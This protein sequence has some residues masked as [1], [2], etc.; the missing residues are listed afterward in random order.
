[1]TLEVT[2]LQIQEHRAELQQRG[3]QITRKTDLGNQYD[4]PKHIGEGGDRLLHLRGGLDL[5]IRDNRFWQRLLIKQHHEDTFPVVAKFYLSGGSRVRTKNAPDIAA[6]YEEVAG[7]SYL[8][9]LPSLVETE[10]WP[11]NI[12]NR[13]VMIYAD[14]NYFRGLYP[15]DDQLPRPLQHLMQKTGRFHRS[16]GEMTPAMIQILQQILHCPYHG[17]AQR[18]Y[19]E[20]KALE[21]LALQFTGLEANTS[22]PRKPT[23]KADD[24]ERVQYAK[25]VLV[26]QVCNPPSLTELARLSGLNEFKLKQGFRQLFDT[27]VFG[28]LYNY[29]MEQAQYLLQN[30]HNK[31]AVVSAQVGYR[32]P[33]AFSMAFRRKFAVSPKAYQLGRINSA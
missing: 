11:A 29:R 16:L 28:Y 4:L 30:P 3:E 21:L 14:V 24:L 12:N 9:H 5:F 13:M 10:E 1:M 2:D 22:N 31:I 6:D 17:S 25:E 20:S 19:L 15:I 32:N 8:Y 18:L 33:E 27:T 23:L 26:E 7:R